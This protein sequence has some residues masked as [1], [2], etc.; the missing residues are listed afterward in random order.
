MFQHMMRSIKK[1]KK[2]NKKM[3]WEFVKKN[4][5]LI[6]EFIDYKKSQK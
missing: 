1:D 6:K 3:V 2:I 4:K 5:N